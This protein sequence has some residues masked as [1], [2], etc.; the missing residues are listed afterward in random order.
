MDL[1]LEPGIPPHTYTFL[2]PDGSVAAVPGIRLVAFADL[3]QH[4]TVPAFR[5]HAIQKCVVYRDFIGK[6]DDPQ[7]ASLQLINFSPEPISIL[8]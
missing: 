3:R 1:Y 2:R 4:I 7:E 8:L 6:R 5:P